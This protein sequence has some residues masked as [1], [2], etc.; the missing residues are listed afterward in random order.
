MDKLQSIVVGVDFTPCSAVALRQAV[1]IGA[2]NRARVRAVHIID[3]LVATE[4]S[5]ALS[6][7]QKDVYDQLTDDAK[8]A[9]GSFAE[10]AGAAGVEIDIGIDSRVDG[11]CKRAAAARADLIVLGCFGEH[12]DVGVGTMATG[13]VRSASSPVLLVRDTQTGPFR[14]IVACVDFSPTSLGAL[15]KAARVAAQD[16]A[17]L[18]I[19]HVFSAPWNI[20]HYRSPTPE[21]DPNFRQQY[22]DGLRRRLEAFGEPL[23]HLLSFLKPRVE[24]VEYRGHAAGLIEY[25]KTVGAD[26]VVLGTRGHTNLRDLLLGSTAERM[27]RQCTCSILAVRPGV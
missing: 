3:V 23:N 7:F 10:P 24:L 6:P 4:L 21:A 26:L 9:W 19:V 17:E 13:C 11:L 18:H 5:E 20:L 27:L 14:K 22:T 12:P 1:R 15:E 2:W 16:N 8:K 25:T